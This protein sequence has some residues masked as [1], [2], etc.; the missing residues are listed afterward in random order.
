MFGCE[1]VKFFLL[2]TG[3]G[4]DVKVG[5]KVMVMVDGD[6]L[7]GAIGVC[8]FGFWGLSFWLVGWFDRGQVCCVL[9]LRLWMAFCM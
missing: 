5:G 4:C 1:V 2:L 9:F 6:E 7:G 8:P 3:F